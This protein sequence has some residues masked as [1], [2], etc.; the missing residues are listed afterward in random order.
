M[1]SRMSGQHYPSEIE[2]LTTPGQIL[3]PNSIRI[4][5]VERT[6]G[7]FGRQVNVS[8]T[9]ERSRSSPEHVLFLDPS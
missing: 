1:P 7:T 3:I 5:D 9:A 4:C 2:R 6:S 8:E